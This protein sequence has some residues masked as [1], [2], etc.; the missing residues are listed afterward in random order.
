MI[1]NY[2]KEKGPSLPVDVSKATN[3]EVIF[4]SAILSGMVSQG[5]VKLT[6]RRIGNS[7]LYY[8]PGQEDRVKSIIYERLSDREKKLVEKIKKTGFVN[9]SELTPPER[10]FAGELRDFLDAV[11]LNDEKYWKHFEYSGPITNPPAAKEPEPERAI[12][13]LLIEKKPE[14]QERL[15]LK[16]VKLDKADDD[17]TS[18]VKDFFITRKIRILD[19]EVI[20]AGS[21]ANFVV[22]IQSD[23]MPQK[24]FVKARKKK[25]INEKD[26]GMAWF[27]FR[28]KKMPMLYI[29]NGNLNKK[30]KEFLEKEMGDN[31][32]FVKVKL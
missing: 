26:L 29:S 13:K 24:Y 8:V 28:D 6:H 4:A 16:P 25:T 5:L 12:V 30:G 3:Q 20:R 14:S 31:L 9:D 27:E 19:K 22:E 32:K 11:E 17:F 2:L 23:L 10:F 18:R 7:P 1:I 21:E 15:D